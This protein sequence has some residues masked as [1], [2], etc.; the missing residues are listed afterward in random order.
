MAINYVISYTFTPGTTISSSQVNTNFSDNANTWTGL[1]ALTKS[2]SNLRVDTTPTTST[3]VAIKSYVDKLNNYRRPVLQYNSGTVVN[4]ETGINGTSGQAQILFPDGTLRTDST[5]TRINCNLAQNAV[6]SG[7]AQSGLRTGSQSANTWY[8]FYAVKV[9]DSTTN[10]VTVADT[11][12]PLQANFATLNSN[13]G[14]NSWVFL[15]T[16]PNGDKNAATNVILSFTML[17]NCV[18]LR[19]TNNGNAQQCS[20]IL[21]GTQ[22]IAGATLTVSYAAGTNIGT[23]QFPNQFGL[24]YMTVAHNNAAQDI[25]SVLDGAGNIRRAVLQSPT[26]GANFAFPVT[27]PLLDGIQVTGN[28]G[29]KRDIFLSAYWDGVLGIGANPI[30]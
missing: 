15:G 2:F 4:L 26:T 21:V 6:L 29:N 14:T 13:F 9:S 12:L 7:S 23:P 20:G 24:S 5:T 17:G 27:I 18:M 10:F 8:S 19:N 28:A 16:L 30:L 11:V 25:T 3:D 22:S 1:E